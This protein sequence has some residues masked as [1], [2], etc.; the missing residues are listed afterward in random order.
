MLVIF[1]V[2]E[3]HQINLTS[4]HACTYIQLQLLQ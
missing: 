3:I 2:R 4:I 1:F